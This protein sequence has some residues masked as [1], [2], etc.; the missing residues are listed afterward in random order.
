MGSLSVPC[1]RGERQGL[2][3]GQGAAWRFSEV[4]RQL[5]AYQVLSFLWEIWIR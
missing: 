4:F 2:E 3:R 5:R 1:V